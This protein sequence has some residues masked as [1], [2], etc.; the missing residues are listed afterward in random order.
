MRAPGLSQGPRFVYYQNARM[1]FRYY[2]AAIP[3]VNISL[4]WSSPVVNISSWPAG[5][6][7]AKHPR[8]LSSEDADPVGYPQVRNMLLNAALTTIPHY[9]GLA[10]TLNSFAKVLNDTLETYRMNSEKW[11]LKIVYLF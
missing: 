2:L 3:R 10:E 8:R 6:P 7:Q 5:Y 1:K 4:R 11:I 9:D